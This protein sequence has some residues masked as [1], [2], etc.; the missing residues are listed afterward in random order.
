[1]NRRVELPGQ[2]GQSNRGFAGKLPVPHT[3]GISVSGDGFAIVN[4]AAK[5]LFPAFQKNTFGK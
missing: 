1:M 4:L 5:N 3:E 2:S